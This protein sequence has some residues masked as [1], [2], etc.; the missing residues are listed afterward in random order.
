MHMPVLYPGDPAE[1]LDLGRHAIAMSRLTG[2]WSAL[3]IVADVAD[4]TASV[5]LHPERIV[6]VL[7]RVGDSSTATAPTRS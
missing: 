4:A 1:A 3:K 2:L 7:P 6:P 5:H